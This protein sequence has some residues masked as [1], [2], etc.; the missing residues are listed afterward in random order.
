MIWTRSS[1]FFKQED[2]SRIKKKI[3]QEK[4]YKPIEIHY[5]IFI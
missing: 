3:P 4:D 2:L 1:S 5:D